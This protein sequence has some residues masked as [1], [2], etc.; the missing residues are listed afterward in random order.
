MI[1]GEFAKYLRQTAELDNQV[2]VK[3]YKIVKYLNLPNR[4]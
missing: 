1:S 3:L 2:P 4:Y